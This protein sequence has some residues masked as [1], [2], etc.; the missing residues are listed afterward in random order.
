[1]SKEICERN[2]LEPRQV[3][4]KFL[5]KFL[6]KS[7]SEE[8]ADLQESWANLMV[9]QSINK[10]KCRYMYYMDILGKLE[11]IDAVILEQYFHSNII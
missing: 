10:Y 3:A 5:L 6:E 8:N 4:P 7:G 9:N 1:M 11:P 2:K